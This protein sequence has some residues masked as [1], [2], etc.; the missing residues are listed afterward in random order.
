M[1][2]PDDSLAEEKRQPAYAI[3]I[4]NVD[5]RGFPDTWQPS[6]KRSPR[7]AFC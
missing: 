7:M 4:P 6:L 1:V 5:D 2:H 3:L